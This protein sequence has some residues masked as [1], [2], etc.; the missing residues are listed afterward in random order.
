MVEAQ[1][2]WVRGVLSSLHDKNYLF[3]VEEFQQPVFHVMVHRRY[4][5]FVAQRL[6]AKK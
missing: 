3:A 4:E 2:G 5:D 1:Q 6:S